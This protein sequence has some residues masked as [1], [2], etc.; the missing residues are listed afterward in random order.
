MAINQTRVRRTTRLTA[1]LV[2]PRQ[3]EPPIEPSPNRKR[4]TITV[5]AV[6]AVALGSLAAGAFGG[7]MVWAFCELDRLIHE[8]QIS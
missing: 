2:L 8:E 5:A 1:A 3:Q 4:R 6:F 7:L